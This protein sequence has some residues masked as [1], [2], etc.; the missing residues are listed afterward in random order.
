MAYLEWTEI[1]TPLQDELADIA[2]TIR[3]KR[4]VQAQVLRS[5]ICQLCDGRYLGR[6]VLA[7]LLKRN[8]DDLLK[9]T[10][11][12]MVA[13]GQ[14]KPAHAASSDPRQA[15]VA[16]EEPNRLSDKGPDG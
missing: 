15:Y 9:R 4:H 13:D 2:Q 5:V 11:N 14:L 16:S 8:A 6:H 10:L 1:P 12:P 3:R 7:H